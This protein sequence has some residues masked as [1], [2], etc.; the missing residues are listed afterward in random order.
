MAAKESFYEKYIIP[1]IES[2][3]NNGVSFY[4]MPYFNDSENSNDEDENSI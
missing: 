4:G 3:G 1:V 2:F